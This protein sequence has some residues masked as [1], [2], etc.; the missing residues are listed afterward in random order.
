MG[1]DVLPSVRQRLSGS[2]SKCSDHPTVCCTW[3]SV[4][5]WMCYIKWNIEVIYSK[6]VT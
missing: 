3:K 6:R 4:E 5:C 1:K 2:K